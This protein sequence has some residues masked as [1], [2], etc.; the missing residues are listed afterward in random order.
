MFVSGIGWILS[1]VALIAKDI[2]HGLGIIL[3]LTTLLSPFAYTSEMVPQ[4]LK[5]LIVANPLSY[6]VFVFQ[7]LIAYGR[8]PSVV[9][10]IG[11]TL[12]GFGMFFLGL[13]VF[14]RSKHVFFD[15]A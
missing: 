2:Q 13:S 12:L 3:M 1:L 8:M 11:T 14:A 9:A 7:D 4:A 15:H 5:P 10:L 6:F